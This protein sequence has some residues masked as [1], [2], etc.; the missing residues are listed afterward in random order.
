MVE[1][2]GPFLLAGF[3]KTVRTASPLAHLGGVCRP[4]MYPLA[5]H[6]S[7]LPVCQPHPMSHLL[8]AARSATRAAHSALDVLSPPCHPLGHACLA[9]LISTT[10]SRSCLVP[11]ADVSS[12]PLGVSPRSSLPRGAGLFAHVSLCLARCHVHVPRTVPCVHVPSTVPCALCSTTRCGM[13]CIWRPPLWWAATLVTAVTVV[14]SWRQGLLCCGAT[15][16]S[17]C[18][19]CSHSS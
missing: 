19:D 2:D 13:P 9:P 8:R 17:D 14:G 10:S 7:V 6:F 11:I 18:G 1:L 15:D 5:H 4:M 16:G 3:T 12:P